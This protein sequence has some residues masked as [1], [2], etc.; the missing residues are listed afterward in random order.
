MKTLVLFLAM[1]AVA[2][3]QDDKE[4]LTKLLEDIRAKKAQL[5]EMENQILKQLGQTKVGNKGEV[6]SIPKDLLTGTVVINIGKDSGVQVGDV[7]KVFRDVKFIAMMHAIQV[8][9]KSTQCKVAALNM[10]E[11]MKVGDKVEKGNA[12]V[13][14]SGQVDGQIIIKDLDPELAKQL[15]AT[16]I[17]SLETRVQ[18]QGW[19]PGLKETNKARYQTELEVQAREVIAKDLAAKWKE[20]PADKKPALEALLKKNLESLYDAK[21]KAKKLEIEEI[22]QRLKK[23]K[24]EAREDAQAKQKF[25][26]A[27]LKELTGGTVE[28]PKH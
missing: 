8:E 9:P 3:A 18:Q 15:G 16:G 1:A 14:G 20:A 11:E 26:A 19:L 7:F 27:R 22:D 4:K 25:V 5:E 21:A 2:F 17:K 28:T 24:D 13:I 10:G 6:T 12:V 23:V